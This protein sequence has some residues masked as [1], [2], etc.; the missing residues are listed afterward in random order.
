[1]SE[2]RHVK[3]PYK[4]LHSFYIT[5]SIFFLP[6]CFLGPKIYHQF[7]FLLNMRT[8]VFIQIKKRQTQ[9]QSYITTQKIHVYKTRIIIRNIYLRNVAT[10]FGNALRPFSSLS[11][12]P[13]LKYHRGNTNPKHTCIILYMY[14]IR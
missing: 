14:S 10:C 5:S 11:G 1:M 6:S 3:Y 13:R 7:L 8:A 2:R 9:T 12:Y 4:L